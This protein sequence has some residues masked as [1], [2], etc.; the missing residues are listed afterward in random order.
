[1]TKRNWS[2]ILGNQPVRRVEMFMLPAIWV[3]DASELVFRMADD[4]QAFRPRS[5]RCVVDGPGEGEVSQI[6]VGNRKM[7]FDSV[8][9]VDVYQWSI[10]LLDIQRHDF[11]VEYGLMGKSHEE[12]DQFL[13]ENGLSMPD[14]GRVELPTITPQIPFRMTGMMKRDVHFTVIGQAM[15]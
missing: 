13:D 11:L 6:Y 8:G 2:K 10:K 1:M 4:I 5:I 7:F 12:V 9:G 3:K 14:P 15:R